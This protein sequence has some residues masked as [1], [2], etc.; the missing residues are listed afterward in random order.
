MAGGVRTDD[1]PP[2]GEME[3]GRGEGKGYIIH[4]HYSLLDYLLM[5][6]L[7][8]C[9]QI[10]S[11]F[12]FSF[13]LIIIGIKRTIKNTLKTSLTRQERASVARCTDI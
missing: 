10:K 12:W 11:F 3:R 9:F 1:R 4:R 8:T 5:Y 2:E 6:Q 13:S 7:L